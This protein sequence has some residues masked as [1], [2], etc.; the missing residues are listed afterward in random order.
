M[1]RC[2]LPGVNAK[3]IPAKPEPEEPHSTESNT[4]H[5][6]LLDPYRAAVANLSAAAEKATTLRQLEQDIL[7]QVAKLERDREVALDLA[8]EV[9][10]DT[11]LDVQELNIISAKLEV[12]KRKLSD[13]SRRAQEAEQ[14]TERQSA[15]LAGRFEALQRSYALWLTEREVAKLREGLGAP[16]GQN[17][18][19]TVARCT[20][21]VVEVRNLSMTLP[22][23]REALLSRVAAEPGFIV[24]PYAMPVPTAAPIDPDEPPC[25]PRGDLGVDVAL[26]FAQYLR[27]DP[28]MTR[29]R[30]MKRLYKEHPE[31][32]VP[33]PSDFEFQ[34]QTAWLA[35]M[36]GDTRLAGKEP[37]E[38]QFSHAR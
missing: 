16:C 7:G 3:R 25:A 21:P 37:V 11:P 30:A 20:K 6:S 27:E 9:D 8:S 13:L 34:Q 4:T 18:L 14:E 26:E 17:L 32:F 1:E 28:S 15:T 12:L 2:T 35:G 24:P 19:E 23:D 10:V 38:E 22:A 5:R 31:I 36:I 33:L 29:P